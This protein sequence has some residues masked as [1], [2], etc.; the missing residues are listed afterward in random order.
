MPDIDATTRDKGAASGD[1][2]WKAITMKDTKVH[3][4]LLPWFPSCNLVAFVVK[5]LFPE[6]HRFTRG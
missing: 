2:W 4:G 6:T 3:E 1:A 5:V